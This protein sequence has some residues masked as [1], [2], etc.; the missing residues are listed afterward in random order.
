MVATQNK[1]DPEIPLENWLSSLKVG[2]ACVLGGPSCG[3]AGTVIGSGVPENPS[4]FR[5]AGMQCHVTRH[6]I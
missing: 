6:A 5:D 4:A 3:V 1:L 2:R